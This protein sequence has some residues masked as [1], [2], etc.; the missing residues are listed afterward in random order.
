MTSTY[1]QWMKDGLP[2]C[3]DQWKLDKQVGRDVFGFGDIP[4][5]TTVT[6]LNLVKYFQAAHTYLELERV[7]SPSFLLAVMKVRCVNK[8][9]NVLIEI[10]SGRSI[11]R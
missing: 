6:S 1:F 8:G 3:K 4:S 2:R 10:R 9:G 5:K 7:I 11:S